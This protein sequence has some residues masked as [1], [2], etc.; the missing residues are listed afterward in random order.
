MK[1]KKT[2]KLIYAACIIAPVLLVL[3]SL[4][5][6]RYQ[7]SLGDV[8]T[9][10]R[11]RIAGLFG[12]GS[13]LAPSIPSVVVWDIR[14][15]RA[16]TALL[17]GGALAVGGG[18]L[19]SV[20]RNPLV[21]TRMMGI[22]AGA[23]FG[24]CLAI[25]IFG[26]VNMSYLF[27]FVFGIG[28]MALAYMV[29]KIYKTAPTVTLVLGGVIIQAI[30]SAL[31]SFTKYA[32]DPFDQLPTI[33]FWL[34]GSLARSNYADLLFALIPITIGV[35]GIMLV[36]WRINLLAIG[37]KEAQT[38]GVNTGVT[39]AI[40][41]I[42][43]ALATAAA[44]CVSGTIGWVGLIIPHISRMLVG[45]DNRVLLPVSFALGACFMLIVDNL[46]RTITSGEIPL[47]ILTALIGGPFFIYL[48]KKTKGGGSW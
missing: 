37:D 41:I 38:L 48:L 17:V 4:L 26:S 12:G 27:A 15:P 47:D 11:D 40:V 29:G 21:D 33:T 5:I 46:A 2:L 7:I 14:L 45:N 9:I 13:G 23:G 31:I 42:C 24:A 6:G 20:F 25:L 35:T 1:N 43:V 39:R 44:I 8:I 22:Q 36:R 18:A 30:F 34:M 16:L 19:Q 3:A 10:L 32:A 28:A